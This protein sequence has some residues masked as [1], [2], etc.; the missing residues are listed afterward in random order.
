MA[1][2]LKCTQSQYFGRPNWAR[3]FRQTRDA[4]LGDH[5]G[6]FLCGSPILGQELARQAA[7][8]SAEVGGTRFSFFKEYF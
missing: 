4:H 2:E 5:V 8:F 7:R 1:Q 3:I 6:V